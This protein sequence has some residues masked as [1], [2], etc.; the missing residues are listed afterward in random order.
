MIEDLTDFQLVMK[1]II[2]LCHNS[3][4]LNPTLIQDMV[5]VFG[6]RFW[7]PTECSF[8][9]LYRKGSFRVLIN[10]D[11][12]IN[13]QLKHFYM[14]KIVFFIQRI[15][16]AALAGTAQQFKMYQSFEASEPP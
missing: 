11:K 10:S 5:T 6:D 1:S 8:S 9:F 4:F 12:T 3:I 13:K 16:F 15:L 7:P 2:P 14:K